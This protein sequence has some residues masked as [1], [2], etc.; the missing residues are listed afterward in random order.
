MGISDYKQ[1]RL[2]LRF[3]QMP[4]CLW[5]ILYSYLEVMHL[6]PDRIEIRVCSTSALSRTY[7]KNIN[8]HALVY[9]RANVGL[10]EIISDNWD[11]VAVHFLFNKSLMVEWLD[12][13]HQLHEI[14]C[15]D[16]EVMGSNH[17]QVKLEMRSNSV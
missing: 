4:D 16:L 11:N 2:R 7:T 14:Y 1:T 17:G 12:W 15:H 3:Y 8:C 10:F 5:D 9:L 13:A 6:N